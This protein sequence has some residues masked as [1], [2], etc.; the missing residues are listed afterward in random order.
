MPFSCNTALSLSHFIPLILA[1]ILQLYQITRESPVLSPLHVI[2][3]VLIGFSIWTW[4]ENADFLNVFL[5]LCWL[6]FVLWVVMV[7]GGF[8]F[9][10]LF[11]CLTEVHR[12]LAKTVWYLELFMISPILTRA[13]IPVEEKQTHSLIL[14]QPCFFLFTKLSCFG[15]LSKMFYLA[16]IRQ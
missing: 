5:F 14:Q 6:G 13:P 7:L 16:A 3:Q 11:R 9:F 1:K 8:V 4:T 12:F 15:A 2:P 10:F